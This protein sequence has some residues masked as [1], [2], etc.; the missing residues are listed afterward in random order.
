MS[1]Q[2]RPTLKEQGFRKWE[3]QETGIAKAVLE[4][5]YHI[6]VRT[7]PDITPIKI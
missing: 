7:S 1:H 5:A 6:Q 4:A 3:N 2:M